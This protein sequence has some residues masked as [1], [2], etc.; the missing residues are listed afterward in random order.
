M[1]I[2]TI[3]I[4]D[5]EETNEIQTDI[6]YDI[7]ENADPDAPITHAALYG[8]AVNWLIRTGKINDFLPE[9]I[10]ELNA[11]GTANSE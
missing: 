5:I 9:V 11:L 7:A 4:K 6:Y 2:T 1:T 3:T 8:Y 10:D